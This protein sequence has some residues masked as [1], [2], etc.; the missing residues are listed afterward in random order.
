MHGQLGTGT[1]PNLMS[2]LSANT[3]EEVLKW[4][5][6][7]IPQDAFDLMW[8]D[9]E[10][11][12]Y[13]TLFSEDIPKGGAFYWNHGTFTYPQTHHWDRPLELAIEAEPGFLRRKRMCAGSR[14]MC[15][16]QLEYLERFMDTFPE[17]PLAG[18]TLISSTTHD[19][20]TNAELIDEHI[21]NFYQRLADKGHLERSVLIFFSD[22]GSRW[23]KIRETFHGVVESKNPFLILTFP[24]W[25]IKKYP[26]IAHNLD[27][28]TRRLTS[29]PD[30]RQMFLDLIYFK[31]LEPTPLY[32]GSHGV[33][34]FNEI[35]P[36]R[37]CVDASIPLDQ[38]LCG[39]KTEK[40]LQSNSPEAKGLA[41]V[42][43]EAVKNKSDPQKC[44]EYRLGKVLQ[45]KMLSVPPVDKKMKQVH[46]VF[47]VRISV[48]PGDAMFEGTVARHPG[49]KQ[50]HTGSNIERLNMYK[51][52]VECQPTS[53]EQMYCFCKG[54]QQGKQKQTIR[55]QDSQLLFA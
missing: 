28:N 24:P 10:K 51:G 40:F 42:L 16:Y 53:R 20:I 39:R 8:H 38:C 12:G 15:E 27:T 1:F 44:A 52:E 18:L 36:N 17:Q 6:K 37:T 35:P 55:Q 19:V 26:E 9:F 4:W 49:T 29:H 21:L 5:N 46:D 48:E 41:S 31:G 2:L 7:T 22:H 25:F 47:R 14:S 32:R 3:E 50:T 30:T 45:V 34:L 43:L 11:A 23:G 33:S 54:N 13:R